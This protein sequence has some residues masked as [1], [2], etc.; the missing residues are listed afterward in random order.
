MTTVVG[1]YAAN[2]FGL[3]D[4]LGNVG[5]LVED[6]QHLSYEGAPGDGRAWSS[7]CA[8]FHGGDMVIH[9]G[10]SYNSGPVGASPTSRG[11]AGKSNRSSLGEGFRIAED[12]VGDAEQAA[13]ADARTGKSGFEDGLRLAQAAERARRTQAAAVAK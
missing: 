6:C 5:E 13:G 4:M 9:R 11:H 10:G 7:G 2:A 3:H 8:P 1:M 12:V